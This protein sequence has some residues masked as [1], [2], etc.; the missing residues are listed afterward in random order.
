MSTSTTTTAVDQRTIAELKEARNE[1]VRVVSETVTRLMEEQGFSRDRATNL[2]LREIGGGH[3]VPDEVELGAMKE[4]YHLAHQQAARALVVST[5]LQKLVQCPHKNS[6]TRAEAVRQLTRR[7]VT[8][9]F[10]NVTTSN[11]EEEENTTTPN[12]SS[13]SL[14]RKSVSDISLPDVSFPQ[15]KHQQ[16]QQ[17]APVVQ[18]KNNPSTPCNKR[19]KSSTSNKNISKGKNRKRNIDEIGVSSGTTSTTNQQQQST[20]NDNTE[21]T[22]RPRADSVTEAVTAKMNQPETNSKAPPSSSSRSKRTR[23]TSMEEESSSSNKRS[24]ALDA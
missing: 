5:A 18:T 11:N 19:T 8:A 10:S 4:R 12:E 7:I 1:F 13:L 24:R 17:S 6:F 14:P 23:G 16:Q 22:T 3:V 9:T 20:A 2:L 15:K 21:P